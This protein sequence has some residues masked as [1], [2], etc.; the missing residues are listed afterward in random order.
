MFYKLWIYFRSFRLNINRILFKKD[1]IGKGDSKLV[2]MISLWLGPIGTLLAVGVSYVFAA[3][4]CLV[5]LSTG[6]LKLRE[7]IPFAPFL[8]LG[9]LF[10]WFFGNEFIF[11][12]ILLF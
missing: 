9:S 1:A 3:F 5:G 7:V 8:S 2:A 12:K 10:I 11:E 6:F 4:Y